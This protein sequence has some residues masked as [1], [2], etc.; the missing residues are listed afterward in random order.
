MTPTISE[1]AVLQADP[2]AIVTGS[3]DPQG[4]DNLDGWRR[5]RALRAAR[6]GNLITVN[7]DTLH[8]PSPRVADGARELCE[9]LDRLRGTPPPR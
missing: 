1:E 3:V 5:L 9:R 6:E 8:R 2:D 7:P 4:A